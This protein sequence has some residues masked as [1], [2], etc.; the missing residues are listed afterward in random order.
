MLYRNIINRALD[1]FV[2]MCIA[3]SVGSCC[4]IKTV[5]PVEI[6]DE[7]NLPVPDPSYLGVK[8]CISSNDFL[9][10]VKSNIENPIVKDDKPLK[11]VAEILASEDIT[12]E[13][14][15]NVLISPYKPGEWID[16]SVKTYQTVREAFGCFLTPWKW[17]SCWRD[18][19]KEV[20]VTTKMWVEPQLAV[21]QW[22]TVAVT[23]IVDKIFSPEVTV[24]YPTYLDDIKISFSGNKFTIVGYTTTAAKIDV[25]SRLLPL[26]PAVKLK[27]LLGLDISCEVTI[28]GDITITNDKTL[29]VSFNI[30]KLD[31]KT[32][33]DKLPK[34]A[35]KDFH[36]YL[37]TDI[38]LAKLTESL[39]ESL[40]KKSLQKT[41]E[42]LLEKN[43]ET[44]DF[45]QK[46]DYATQAMSGP[47]ELSKDIWL[48]LN[49][50]EVSCSQLNGS[51]D[52]LC[53]DI[54][55]KFEPAISY[56][57]Q[58]PSTAPANVPFKVQDAQPPVTNI[59][60]KLSAS[61]DKLET[62]VSEGINQELVSNSNTILKKLYV[63]NVDMYRTEGN[64]IVILLDVFSKAK[65]F[66]CKV[67]TAYLI[68]DLLYEDRIKQFSLKDVN[69]DVQTRSRLLN[70]IYKAFVDEKMEN[71]IEEKAVFN[72]E[73]HFRQAN[74]L[75]A[76]LSYN[77]DYG[78]LSGDA[79]LVKLTGPFISNTSVDMF[80]QLKADYSFTF[81]RTNPEMFAT[82]YLPG[83]AYESLDLKKQTIDGKLLYKKNEPLFNPQIGKLQDDSSYDAAKR[84]VLLNKNLQ[85]D[86]S[87][88]N[89]IHFDDA[90]DTSRS[91]LHLLPFNAT[92]KKSTKSFNGE[93][94]FIYIIDGKGNRIKKRKNFE[95]QILPGEEFIFVDK[96]GEIKKRVNN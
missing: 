42:K 95:D 35:G 96:N 91:N 85:Q 68:A 33:L 63:K 89:H 50:I 5:R 21:Y 43:N 54:G 9:L 12:F 48:N 11:V 37:F 45:K 52:D 38:G 79:S 81:T 60:L 69:F 86:F 58:P 87:K 83:V 25:E 8:A 84:L 80:A 44:L 47:K 64:K 1:C 41:I 75:L 70:S 2:I 34:I 53:I 3:F 18:V 56:T 46:I 19:L 55:V 72:I 93:N 20:W 23:K 31:I 10:A 65:L 66:K 59:N 67:F 17:G 29:A 74:K 24:H 26:T 49:P 6:K 73:P 22:Q 90:T 61:L 39:V 92:A 76:K 30:P 7:P 27:N 77:N 32:P 78:T 36:Q 94:D 13:T 62:L 14:L 57:L 4:A 16:V 88:Y 28:T 71:I 15:V 82:A 51:G 40:G